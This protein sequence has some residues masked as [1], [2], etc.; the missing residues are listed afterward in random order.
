MNT[1]TLVTP[2]PAQAT[3]SVILGDLFCPVQV[4]YLIGCAV[5]IECDAHLV[6]ALVLAGQGNAGTQRNLGMKKK[7]P[8]LDVSGS[9]PERTT[10]CCQV[11]SH[12]HLSSHNAVPSVEV[13]RIHVHGA[14]FAL[15]HTP[16]TT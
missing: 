2:L 13:G 9:K 14:A 1:S 8:E 7:N 4:L 11:V 16:F 6:V 10:R 12:L 15:G 5:S 3:E